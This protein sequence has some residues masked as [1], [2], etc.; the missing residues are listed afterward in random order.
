[1]ASK[2][3]K[4]FFV[5]KIREFYADISHV[6]LMYEQKKN[7]E[8]IYTYLYIGTGPHRIRKYLLGCGF[9]KVG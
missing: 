4:T 7:H 2:I 8:G 5:Y 6:S 3:G 1:M 9:T